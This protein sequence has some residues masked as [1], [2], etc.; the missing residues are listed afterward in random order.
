M[1]RKRLL[2]LTKLAQT[3]SHDPCV[4]FHVIARKN[5][6]GIHDRKRAV[7]YQSTFYMLY[8]PTDDDGDKLGFATKELAKKF[9]IFMGLEF[10]EL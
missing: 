3:F 1:N 4:A 10:S 9:C 2:K 6:I 5:G 8:V 7:G